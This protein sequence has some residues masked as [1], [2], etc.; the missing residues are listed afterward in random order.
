M[1]EMDSAFYR[2][3]S[4]S[5]RVLPDR[6]THVRAAFDGISIVL[7]VDGVGVDWYPEGFEWIVEEDWPPFPSSIARVD[8]DLYISHPARF[9]MGGLDQIVLRSATDPE[10]VNLPID[11]EL[12]GPPQ[13]IYLTGNGSLNP[14]EHDLPV[15][16]HLAEVGDLAELEKVDGTAVARESFRDQMQ[17]KKKEREEEQ[18]KI[19]EAFGSPI[20]DLMTY[21]EDWQST[22]DDEESTEDVL[23]LPLTPGL[24]FGIGEV[25]EHTVLRM[26]NIVVDLTGAIRG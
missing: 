21:L 18:E 20:G 13:L 26:H 16:I 1:G 11:V 15:V 9:F 12:L 24:H 6:W 17:R 25:D 2:A 7:E 14:L 23:L 5:R 10:I 4:E 8:S 3:Q 19:E 22:S